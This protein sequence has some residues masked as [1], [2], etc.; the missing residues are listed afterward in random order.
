[1][2]VYFEIVKN[3]FNS[4]TA[5]RANLFF[6]LLGRLIALFAMVSVWSAIFY[7]TAKTNSSAGDISL[8]DMITYVIISTGISIIINNNVAGDIGSKIRSGE[9]AMDLIKPINLKAC[10]LCQTLG[11]NAVKL[12]FQLIPFLLMG[13]LAFGLECPKWDFFVIFLISLVNGL[14]I[15]FFLAYITGIIGF[16]YLSVGHI[17]RLLSDISTLLSGYI[18]PLWFFPKSLLIISDFLPFKLMYF[19]PITI[20]LGKISYWESIA[21]LIQ[22]YLWIVILLVIEKVMW[23]RGVKKL[24]I[25]GG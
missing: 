14:I 22:Q 6:F 17:N 18:V 16:W 9:I 25:Q 19:S 20:Y 2:K 21:I 10:L 8:R 4:N 7:N 15:N 1:M 12:M 23:I 24:V 5:Y 3:T 11:N 13:I